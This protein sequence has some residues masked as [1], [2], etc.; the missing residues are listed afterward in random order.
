M[1]KYIFFA[2]SILFLLVSAAAVFAQTE[3][4]PILAES[5]PLVATAELDS[6]GNPVETNS[7]FY[8]ILN[9]DGT[10]LFYKDGY[11]SKINWNQSEDDNIQIDDRL[12]YTY[13]GIISDGYLLIPV[14]DRTYLFEESGELPIMKLA[15]GQ[16]AKEIKPNFFVEDEATAAQIGAEKAAEIDRKAASF[17]QKYGIDMHIIMVSNFWDYAAS[18]DI[19]IFSEEISDG[20]RLG[21]KND[22]NALLLVM[23]MYDRDY[24][25]YSS[26]FKTNEIF[27]SYS[28]SFLEDAMLPHFK[29]ND[30]AAGMLA[31]LDECEFLLT[32]AENGEIYTS[33]PRNVT[34]E[35]IVSLVIGLLIGLIVRACIK[36][37]Y[38]NQ[39]KEQKA[40]AQYIVGDTFKLNVKTDTY[41]HSTSSRTYSPRSTS[42]SHSGGG[43][44]RSSSHS[45][46]KF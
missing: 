42:N 20:Y 3:N 46:G 22:E 33:A 23:S 18:S 12:G 43:G 41:T 8:I 28:R 37:A 10:G 6:S 21:S 26:G 38:T 39:V 44:S 27:N 9:T 36:A 32:S 2:F 30:W 24:D 34:G 29:Q 4:L 35:I 7:D 17:S 1:R 11:V 5:I 19:E 16:W 31:Y 40:A 13:D 45:S 25:I 15:P 14:K